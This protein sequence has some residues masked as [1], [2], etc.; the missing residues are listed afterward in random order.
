MFLILL[1]L[2]KLTVPMGFCVSVKS[3]LE[4]MI[5][6]ALIFVLTLIY[7]LVQIH[8]AKP[9][10]LLKGGETPEENQKQSGF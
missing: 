2:L 1:K 4:T 9:I 3:I 6:F 7:N 5:L 10:E 8:L